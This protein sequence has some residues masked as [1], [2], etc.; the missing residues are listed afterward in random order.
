MAQYH[1]LVYELHLKFSFVFKEGAYGPVRVPV[2]VSAANA[3]QA[4]EPG[5]QLA[6]W[7][8][9]HHLHPAPVSLHWGHTPPGQEGAN[10]YTH[11]VS[12]S[13]MNSLGWIFMI[14][15]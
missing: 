5:P 14:V 9:Q 4:G 1:Q 11:I 7:D 13:L 12:L 6:Q 15:L 2:L 8:L 3:D 10:T